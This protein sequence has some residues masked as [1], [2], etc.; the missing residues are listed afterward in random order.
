MHRRLFLAGATLVASAPFSVHSHT[1]YRQWMVYRKKHLLIGCHRED[2]VTWELAKQTV[3][4]LA[5]T[6]PD[7]RSRVARAKTPGRLASLLGTDQLQTAILDTETAQKI[8]KGVDEF[9]PYGAI[10]LH[11]IAEVEDRVLVCLADFPAR[12]A[13]QIAHALETLAI[14]SLPELNRNSLPIHSG[15]AALRDGQEIPAYNVPEAQ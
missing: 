1:P 11:L 12:H 9:A 8:V 2:L 3:A 6:L 7:A 5:Q 13:W 15:V 10:P 14:S 4:H